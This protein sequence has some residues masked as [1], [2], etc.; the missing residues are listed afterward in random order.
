ML[1]II[2][3]LLF[4]TACSTIKNGGEG[5]YLYEPQVEYAVDDLK[6][7]ASELVE[8]KQRDP[9]VGKLDELFAPKMPDLKKIGI[10]VFE[11][12]I[13]ETRNG[14]SNEDKIY[15]SAQGKQLLTERFLNIWEE[16]IKVLGPELTLVS[17]GQIKK[18]KRAQQYGSEQED[19]IKAKRSALA[20]DDIFF[21]KKGKITP[22]ETLINPRGMRDVSMLL[23]PAAEL[24]GGPKWSEHNKHY[25]N[26][27]AQEF[28]L[29]AVIVMIS[30]VN[31]T[32][33]RM[34][35]H[36]GEHIAES[37]HYK[38]ETSVLVPLSRYHERL[39]LIGKNEKPN[40]TIA[41]RS[42][43]TKVSIPASLSIP[44]S[45]ESFEKVESALLNPML[46]TYR[47]LSIMTIGQ[48]INDL[49]KT[50]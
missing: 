2:L 44:E 48:I 21:L 35:K 4:L 18:S 39:A 32:T 23:V 31:W 28:E 42:Y 6:A 7:K 14:L 12:I 36:S 22:M 30:K 19:F 38:L 16:T 1:R 29:D 5:A 27:L 8:T 26:E 37:I 33:A 11:S 41:Y 34:D 43:E 20:P 9:Q 15:L 13:Q 3:G 45:E 40:N 17:V 49:K 50:F 10:V 25:L 24:M 46:K 47:D